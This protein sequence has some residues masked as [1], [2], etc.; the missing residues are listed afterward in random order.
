MLCFCEEIRVILDILDYIQPL[1]LLFIVDVMSKYTIILVCCSMSVIWLAS[2]S[3]HHLHPATLD[4]I[5]IVVAQL[6]VVSARTNNAQKLLSHNLFGHRA[7]ESTGMQLQQ[8]T[9]VD[10]VDSK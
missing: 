7:S 5:S 10:G 6:S 1:I 3:T 9:E 4:N 2:S 8:C